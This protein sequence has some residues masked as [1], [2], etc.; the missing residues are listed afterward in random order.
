MRLRSRVG[1]CVH[2][3][4]RELLLLC[5]SASADCDG[6]FS[7]AQFRGARAVCESCKRFGPVFFTDL[8]P[9]PGSGR[10]RRLPRPATR[11][12]TRPNPPGDQPRRPSR[13]D[14]V[15]LAQ[16][17]SRQITVRVKT[18]PGPPR[19]ALVDKSNT[20]RL[21]A[22]FSSEATPSK[23]VPAARTSVRRPVPPRRD[24]PGAEVATR[25]AAP[26]RTP[27]RRSRGRCGCRS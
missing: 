11:A 14:L 25:P 2:L 16:P 12:R 1:G 19:L 3:G 13:E 8:S 26:A 17:L 18:L 7:D 22:C 9:R 20:L 6:E 4:G 23:A 27:R 10:H 15:R 5:P 21:R 24:Y